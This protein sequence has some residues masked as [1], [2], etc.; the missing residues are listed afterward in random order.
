MVHRNQKSLEI[1][2]TNNKIDTQNMRQ[3]IEDSPSQLAAGLEL[4]K[5]V[6]IKGS[7]EKVIVCG[8]GGSALSADITKALHV[9]VEI[10]R[11]YNL[12]KTANEKSLMVCISYSGNTEETVSALE[13]AISKKLPIVGMASGGKIET[14][15]QQNHLPFVKIPSGVQPRSAIGYMFSALM[16]IFTKANMCQDM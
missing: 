16:T 5:Q 14:L 1:A 7:F 15:C 12:P 8:L 13:E 3:V 6:K 2:M 4:A 9:P 10:H 11:D